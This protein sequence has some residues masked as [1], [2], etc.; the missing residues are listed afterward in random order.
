[1]MALF[2]FLAAPACGTESHVIGRFTDDRCDEYGDAL[3]CS[4]FERPDLSEWEQVIVVKDARVEQTDS[5]AFGG[6]GALHAESLGDES[7]GVV[8]REFETITS[9]ALHLR[10]HL[11]VPEGL[12]TDAINIFFLG[13]YATPD[14]FRGVD[15]NLESGALSTYV[16]GQA[17]DRFTSTTL[18]IPRDHWFCLQIAMT[19]SP[20]AGTVTML[21]DGQVGLEQANMKTLPEGGVHLLR[22]GVDWS[23]LQTEPFDIYMD[24]LVLSTSPVDCG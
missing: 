23:S 20:D 8:A 9:G 24:D 19:L 2:A 21:V 6:R 7:A 15:F 11:Y 12:P 5:R 16:P 3:V 14:P 13:D 4:G 1:M 18:T 17:P 22:A 10:A